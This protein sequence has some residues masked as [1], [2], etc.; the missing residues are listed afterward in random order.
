M[1]PLPVHIGL[2]QY[3]RLIK[4]PPT[5][6]RSTSFYRSLQL[7]M[8]SNPINKLKRIFCGIDFLHV[9][10]VAQVG[11]RLSIQRGSPARKNPGALCM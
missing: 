6:G 10:D 9:P 11:P 1:K 8:P 2:F 3:G 7:A 5:S 4:M